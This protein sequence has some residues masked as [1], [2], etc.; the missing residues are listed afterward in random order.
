MKTIKHS[1][2]ALLAITMAA[3]ACKKDQIA[4]PYPGTPADPIKSGAFVTDWMQ[5]GAWMETEYNGEKAQHAVFPVAGMVDEAMSNGTVIVFGRLH[6]YRDPINSVRGES[7]LPCEIAFKTGGG[8]STERWNAICLNGNLQIS[9]SNPNHQFAP[10]GGV[11]EDNSFRVF[12]L[13]QEDIAKIGNYGIAKEDI[14]RISY[15]KLCFLLE[16]AP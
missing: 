7:K 11:R 15:N 13:S 12:F 5:S 10:T 6:E 3:T 2:V 9:V 14:P 1:L 16:V 4:Q 8:F